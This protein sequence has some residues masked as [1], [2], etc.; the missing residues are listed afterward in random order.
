MHIFQSY[1]AYVYV[2]LSVLQWVA[3]IKKP[4]IWVVVSFLIQFGLVYL[5]NCVSTQ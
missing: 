4:E 2:Y 3:A 1:R 5:I